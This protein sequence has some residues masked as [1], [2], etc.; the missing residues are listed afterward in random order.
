MSLKTSFKPRWT[1]QE[2]KWSWQ[3]P[4][5]GFQNPENH[6]DIEL[7]EHIDG[8][9]IEIEDPKQ[10]TV[11]IINFSPEKQNTPCTEI[12]KDLKFSALKE[13]IHQGCPENIKNLPRDL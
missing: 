4:S 3:T 5:V 7:G 8:V 13:V 9:D 12:V 2:P 1:D 10:Y 6:G 11:A